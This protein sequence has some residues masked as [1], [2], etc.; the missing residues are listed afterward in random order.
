MKSV[1]ML[2]ISAS[3]LTGCAAG[4][5]FAML[6]GFSEYAKH[7]EQAESLSPCGE[8]ELIERLQLKR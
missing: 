5:S 6:A 1:L 4:S 7:A 2:T 8:K 3:L